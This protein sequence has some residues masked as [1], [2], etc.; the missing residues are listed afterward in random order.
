MKPVAERLVHRASGRRDLI[1][2]GQNGLFRRGHGQQPERNPG[3]HGKGSLRSAQQLGQV[4]AG[5][6]EAGP[7][8]EDV[9]LA[10]GESH[11]VPP[12][13]LHD[14]HIKRTATKIVDKDLASVS[15]VTGGRQVALLKPK[16]HRRG[17]RLIDDAPDF[18]SRNL[19]GVLGGLAL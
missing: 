14:R 15:G 3:D 1:E 18:E 2:H 11:E 16:C 6:A 4:V 12:R 9:E 8:P 13:Q 17:R 7:L 19:A 10:P 5:E